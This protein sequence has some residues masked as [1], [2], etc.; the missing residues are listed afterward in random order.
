MIHIK[1]YINCLIIPTLL[2][3]EYFKYEH[4]GRLHC[5]KLIHLRVREDVTNWNF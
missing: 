1:E 5:D 3:S 4:E 2:F